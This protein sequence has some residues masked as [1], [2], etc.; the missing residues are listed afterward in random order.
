MKP[1]YAL[2]RATPTQVNPTEIV[3]QKDYESLLAELSENTNALAVNSYQLAELSAFRDKLTAARTFQ[4]LGNTAALAAMETYYNQIAPIG[5]EEY[6]AL[7]KSYV[8]TA[9]L[10]IMGGGR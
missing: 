3:T 6:R 5:R 2:S 7:V 10:E 1:Y 9:A 8:Y 4:A